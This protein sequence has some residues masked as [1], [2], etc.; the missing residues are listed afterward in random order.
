M[1]AAPAHIDPRIRARR[2]AVARAAGRKRLRVIAVIA[3]A[4]VVFGLAYLTVTS[5]LLDVDNVQIAGINGAAA[6]QVR[7]AARVPKHAAMMFLDTGAI[8]RRVEEI[9]WV[10]HA[11]VKRHYPGTVRIVVTEFNPTAFIRVAGHGV[12]LVASTGRVYATAARAPLHARE[13]RGVQLAPPI[14][15]MLAPSGVANITTRLPSAL[16]SRVHAIDISDGLALV[17]TNGG[18][19]RLGSTDDLDAKAAAALAVL[20]RIGTVPFAYLDVTTPQTP[21]LHR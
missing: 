6:T 19:I 14:G 17:L 1:T 4:V 12:L 10:A 13:I 7:T 8:A 2:V 15:T 21:V 20:T 16:A 5:P 9:P 11:S 18:S 3:T